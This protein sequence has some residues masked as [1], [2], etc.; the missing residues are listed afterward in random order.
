[1]TEKEKLINQINELKKE[2]DKCK[3][4][5]NIQDLAQHAYKIFL[6]SIYGALGSVFYPCFDLDNAE[7]VTLSG[8]AVTREMIRFTNK[9]LNELINKNTDE[10]YVIAGDTDSVTGFTKL[11]IKRLKCRKITYKNTKPLI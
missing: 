1:M 7:A 9:I 8:Q 3:D 10:E 11:Q 4:L 5:A 6:N 2:R